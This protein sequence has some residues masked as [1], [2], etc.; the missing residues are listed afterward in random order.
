MSINYIFKDGDVM[1][2]TMVKIETF[3]PEEYVSI[4]R[5]KLNEIGALSIDGNYDYCMTVSKV[6]GSWRPLEGTNPYEGVIGEICEV[7]EI[8]VEFTCCIEVHKKALNTIVKV[9]PYERPVVNV[10]PLI[11]I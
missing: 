1:E 9:H 2:F 6:K 3:I 5:E 4:L 11:L 7:E 10:I 8:K